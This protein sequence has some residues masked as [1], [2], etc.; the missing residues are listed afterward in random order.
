MDGDNDFDLTPPP[1]WW[2][3][4]MDGQAPTLPQQSQMVARRVGPPPPLPAWYAGPTVEEVETALLQQSAPT[5]AAWMDGGDARRQLRT[6]AL[7]QIYHHAVQHPRTPPDAPPP[8]PHT[9]PIEDAVP[10]WVRPPATPPQAPPSEPMYV[11]TPRA[12]DFGRLRLSHEM[13]VAQPSFGTDA[14]TASIAASA[15]AARL[16]TAWIRS[17]VH[18]APEEQ[19][20]YVADEAVAEETLE[21]E[22]QQVLTPEQRSRLG[23][24]GLTPAWQTLLLHAIT[25]RAGAAAAVAALADLADADL[26]VLLTPQPDSQTA[27]QTA[28]QTESQTRKEARHVQFADETQVQL[29]PPHDMDGL[30]R[31]DAA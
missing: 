8:P 3:G 16:P 10:A 1:L 2:G 9:W 30:Y 28:S 21:E 19:D 5:F 29:I 11:A 31:D 14:A 6:R 20:E 7:A 13:E 18:D 4:A 17:P 22:P 12:P 27:S 24:A 15:A 25:G 23:A 26:V